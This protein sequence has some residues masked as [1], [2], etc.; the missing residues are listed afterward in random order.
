MFD[1]RILGRFE[2]RFSAFLSEGGR[3]AERQGKGQG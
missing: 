1:H 3:G 2:T